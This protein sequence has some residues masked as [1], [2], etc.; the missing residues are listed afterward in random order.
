[1]VGRKEGISSKEKGRIWD[2]ME[3]EGIVM[4]YGVV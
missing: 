2:G 3:R 4:V 1:M